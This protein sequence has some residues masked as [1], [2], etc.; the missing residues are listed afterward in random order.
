VVPALS[1]M[2]K[3]TVPVYPL[4]R[5][6]YASLAWTVRLKAVPAEA[7]EGGLENERL[8]AL[9]ELM[10]MAVVPLIELEVSVALTVW[11]PEVTSVK[12]TVCVPLF[13]DKN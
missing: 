1:V 5:L 6:P 12:L 9:A 10:V 8:L 3:E 13:Y 2:V 4:A 7:V 11:L